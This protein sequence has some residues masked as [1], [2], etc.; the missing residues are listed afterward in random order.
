MK[1][2]KIH[3]FA[4]IMATILS[5]AVQ[6]QTFTINGKVENSAS[7]EKVAAASVTVKGS[8][9]GTFTDDKGNFK[10]AVPKLPVTLLISSVGYELQEITVNS[11]NESLLISFN[12]TNSLGQE[13]VISATKTAQKIL[14]SPVSIER[15]NAATIRNSPAVNYYDIIGSLKGVDIV[16]S[17]LTF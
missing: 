5:V 14:E 6:A 15:I 7:K 8:G 3:L 13:V 11:S 10:I 17:S 12:P 1:R 16:S 4:L 9:L 2:H